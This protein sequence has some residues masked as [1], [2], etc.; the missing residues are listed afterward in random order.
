MDM[1]HMKTPLLL[2]FAF[3]ALASSVLRADP[4]R[5][6]IFPYFSPEQLVRLHKPLKDFLQRETG[7]PIHLVSAPDFQ[8]F[9]QRTREGRYDILITAPHL[10]RLAQKQNGYRWLGFTRNYSMAVFVARRDSGIGRLE[11][12]VGHRLALPPRVA[13]IHQLAVTALEQRGLDP[14][15]NL[16]LVP[17][18]SHDQALYAVLRGKADAAAI[19]RPTWRRY[20]APDR[21]AL[22]VIGESEHIPGFAL[23]ID[24]RVKTDTA[25]R[26]RA[27][28]YRF[29]DTAEG[30]DYF[31]ATGLEGIR[32]VTDDDLGQLDHYLARIEAANKP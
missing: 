2:L 22:Q 29:Q 28:L 19:G 3:L 15:H 6:G 9:I 25:D 8:Q 11:D 4:L 14:A 10:G 18:K 21:D 23:L 1:R 16:T 17:E 5:M 30:R 26:I 31:D 27:A 7:Q 12:L 24:K 32:P 13:I 20:E